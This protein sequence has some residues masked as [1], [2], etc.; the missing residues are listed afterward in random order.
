LTVVLTRCD[1]LMRRLWVVALVHI[2][3]LVLWWGGPEVGAPLAAGALAAE[4][5]LGGWWLLLVQERRG[6]C[7]GLIATGGVG[8]PLAALARERERLAS[9]RHQ[10]GLAR[11]IERLITRVSASD[12][13]PSARPPTDP[14]VVG[15]ATR[16]LAEIQR[17]L[18]AGD[19]AAPA[20]ALVEQLI[21]SPMSP[22]YGSDAG[23]LK[24]EL[25]RVRYLA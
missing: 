20:V 12:F 14:R 17:R 21:S 25:A 8:P 5:G 13:M 16:E 22:L 9:P 1:A 7:L 23:E 2:A 4:L 18:E 3:G 10:A 6:A 11:S 15:D 24:R 19:M